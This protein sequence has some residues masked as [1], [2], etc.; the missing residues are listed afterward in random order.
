M[1]FETSTHNC[2]C[3]V[4]LFIYFVQF[5]CIPVIYLDKCQNRLNNG[6]Q[7]QATQ[8]GKRI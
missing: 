7:N 5:I 4:L 2:N 1:D 8:K 3:L 6:K